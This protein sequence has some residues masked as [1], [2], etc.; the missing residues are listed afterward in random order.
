MKAL[1]QCMV[2]TIW[3]SLFDLI[4]SSRSRFSQI[5]FSQRAGRALRRAPEGTVWPMPLPF[6]ELHLPRG[7]RNQKDA[8]RKL[9][10][11]FTVLALNALRFEEKKANAVM[12]GIGTKVE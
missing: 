6:P 8:N 2:C 5:W 9:G 4:C 1:A 12:P 7:N 11:N 10:L 3:N